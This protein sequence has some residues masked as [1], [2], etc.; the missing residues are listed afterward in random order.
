MKNFI[1]FYFIPFAIFSLISRTSAIP[2]AE[3]E[4]A[5]LWAEYGTPVYHNYSARDYGAHFQNWDIIQN[6]QDLILVANNDGLLEY[7]GVSWRR[8]DFDGQQF[9]SLRSLAISPKGEIYCGTGSRFGYLTYNALGSYRF[10]DLTR[11]VNKKY[12]DFNDVWYTLILDS[13]VYFVTH[14][15]I[16][17]WQNNKISVIGFANPEN[18]FHTAFKVHNKIF[19]RQSGVGLMEMLGNVL[20]PIPGGGIFADKA[21][22]LM[23]PYDGNSILIGTAGYGFYLY[24]SE[25]T[26]PFATRTDEFLNA[27]HL[28]CGTRIDDQYYALGTRLGGMAIMDRR[29]N[30]LKIFDTDH[31]LQDNSVWKIYRDREGNLWLA[32]NDGISKIELPSRVSYFN[33]ENGLEGTVE[34]VIRHQNRLYVSTNLGVF[35]LD[36]VN[37]SRS[38][39]FPVFKAVEGISQY[40]WFLYSENDRDLLAGCSGG[41]YRIEKDRALPV[42]GPSGSIFEITASR[43][44][45][46]IFF[47]AGRNGIGLLRKAGYEWRFEGNIPRL[48][49]KFYHVVEEDAENLWLETAGKGLVHVQLLSGSGVPLNRQSVQISRYGEQ[50]G[51]PAERIYPIII[52]NQLLFSTPQGMFRFNKKERSFQPAVRFSKPGIWGFLGIE[53]DRSRLWISRY[54]HYGEDEKVLVGTAGSN[55]IYQWDRRA[56]Q[57]L[58]GIRHVNSIYPENKFVSWIGTSEGLFRYDNRI[59]KA[60]SKVLKTLVRRVIINPDSI[61]FNGFVQSAVPDLDFSYNNLR[62]EYALA[63]FNRENK[64]QYQTF[65]EGFDKKWTDWSSESRRDFTNLPQGDYA[66][67]VKGKNIYNRQGTEAAFRFKILPPWYRSVWAYLLYG[68][69]ILL[70]IVTADR[71]QRRRVIR[72]ELAKARLREAKIIREKNSELEKTLNSLN[73]TKVQLER[74]ESRFRSVVQTANDAIISSDKEGNIIFWNEYAERLFGY[75]RSEAIGK[76]LT[77]IMPEKHRQAHTEGLKRFLSTGETRLMGKV[78]ELEGLR[79]DGSEFPIELTIAEWTTDE[80]EFV[81]G[82]IRD[83]SQRREEQEAKEKAHLLLEAEH[84]HK[85]A[86]LEKARRLQHAMLPKRLP[87]TKSLEIAAFMKTAIEI[88]GDYYDFHQ[89]GNGELTVIIGDATG[90]GLEAGMMVAATKSLLSSLIWEEDLVQIFQRANRVFKNLNLRNLYMSLQALRFNNYEIEVCTA[91]MPPVLVYRQ[92]GRKV[93]EILIKKMPLGSFPDIQYQT[94][95]CRV[96]PGDTI[97]LMSDGFPEQFN[98]NNEIIGFEKTQRIFKETA[99]LSPSAIIKKLEDTAREWG[100]GCAQNDD[101]TFVVLK[102]K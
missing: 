21:V 9:Q 34:K 47:T 78:A 89:S 95:K 61:I 56:L 43:Y 53:D 20:Q 67:R 13:T 54:E 42:E 68:G 14:Q 72:R 90:H 64:N 91:G 26:V 46:D 55:G 80:G 66:F 39:H 71:Y 93:E 33:R 81:T 12:H 3:D 52:G 92:D 74:S 40:S 98:T 59:S 27:S 15:Y 84:K 32:L 73:S 4:A 29:G 65:L 10:N 16:F 51:L 38:G 22:Y 41:V 17:A 2:Q 58:P 23:E 44:H 63:S 36:N 18:I 24:N 86:E 45:P 60:R 57:D 8:Y 5:D 28:Y 77:L 88:G 85:S 99:H 30:L 102:V 49:E 101:M 25:E 87:Q 75:D 79:K 19:I 7:D 76:P 11:L 35:Y 48:N 96:N 82:I 100:N 50:H 6:R 70:G 31:G 97:L 94:K 37:N 83:I 62:F 69:L 1:L